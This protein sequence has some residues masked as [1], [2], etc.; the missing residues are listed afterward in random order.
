MKRKPII[1]M[2]LVPASLSAVSGGMVIDKA[3]WLLTPSRGSWGTVFPL[4]FAM[5]FF[6]LLAIVLPVVAVIREGH[7]VQ[8]ETDVV[9][10][11]TQSRAQS[12]LENEPSTSLDN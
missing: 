8:C 2:F 7:D 10:V 1:A 5:I 9:P 6:G 3:V 11:R 4:G 12:Q